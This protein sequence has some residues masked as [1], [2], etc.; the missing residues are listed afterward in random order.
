MAADNAAI[1]AFLA[2]NKPYNPQFTS[3]QKCPL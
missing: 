3:D 2:L 1:E